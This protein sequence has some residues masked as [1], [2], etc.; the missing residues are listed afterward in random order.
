MLNQIIQNVIDGKAEDF[1]Q[2]D[3]EF[4]RP[5]NLYL[6]MFTDSAS[7]DNYIIANNGLNIDSD[8]CVKFI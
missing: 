4:K 3:I 2:I 8:E 1:E 7:L 6:D 5:I